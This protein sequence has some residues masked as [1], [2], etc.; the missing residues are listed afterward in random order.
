M[1][2]YQGA[3]AIELSG[4]SEYRRV[5]FSDFMAK[6]RF[7]PRTS[8]LTSLATTVYKHGIST[9]EMNTDYITAVLG[10]VGPLML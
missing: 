8:Q 7:E 6:M 10:G 9:T 5:G 1:H 2:T 3:R 4:T